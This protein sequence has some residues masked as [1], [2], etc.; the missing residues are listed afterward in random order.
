MEPSPQP[1]PDHLA[2]LRQGVTAW[3]DWR[4]ANPHVVPDLP[5]AQLRGQEL[6]GANLNHAILWKADLAEAQLQNA[7]LREANLRKANLFHA[8]LSD[9]VLSGANLTGAQLVDTTLVRTTLNGC[10]VYGVS[11]WDATIEDAKQH[12]LVTAD[13]HSSFREWKLSDVKGPLPTVDDIEV[14]QL[15]YL[16]QANKKVT[17][18]INTV[19]SKLVLILGRFTTERKAVLDA[20]KDKLRQDNLVP[21]IFDFDGPETRSLT[22]TVGLLAGLARF[23]IA[24]ITDA[25]SIPQELYAIVPALPSLPV[26]PIISGE[27]YGMFQDFAGYLS[28]LPPFR[29]NDM[30]HL[31]ASLDESVIG[32]VTRKAEEIAERRKAFAPP[33]NKP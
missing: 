14:A 18:F 9:A 6:Q 31:I 12:D 4:A 28:V 23:V 13:K 24:D 3:N 20:L 11:V 22:E 32:P 29:Y 25:K 5:H 19:N 7:E 27:Q 8:D 2:R 1:N 26:Q 21:I 30:Q 16:L 17:N 15:I 10:F 33:E